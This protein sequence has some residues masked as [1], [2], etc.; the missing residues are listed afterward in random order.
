MQS[1][2]SW[3]VTRLQDHSAMLCI[4]KAEA[5]M[6]SPLAAPYAAYPR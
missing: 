1:F 3:C 6:Y 5:G 4:C 2:E